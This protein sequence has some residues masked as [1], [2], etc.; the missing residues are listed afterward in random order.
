M[1]TAIIEAAAESDETLMEKFFE[2][3]DLSE[4]ELINGGF[5]YYST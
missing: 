3:G 5:K 1:R 2:N 4:E